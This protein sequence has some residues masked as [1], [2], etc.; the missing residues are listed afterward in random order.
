MLQW[1]VPL[2]AFDARLWP[3]MS[4]SACASWTASAKWQTPSGTPRGSYSATGPTSP[5]SLPS[6]L[7][8][9]SFGQGCSDRP[10]RWHR[11]SHGGHSATLS[12]DLG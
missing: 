7:P 11:L 4:R 3:L 5:R 6:Q 12:P 1:K 8:L 10:P 2:P 9:Q